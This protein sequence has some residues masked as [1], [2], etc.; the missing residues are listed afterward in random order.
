MAKALFLQ[1]LFFEYPGTMILSAC[2]KRAG[3][4]TDVLIE[5]RRE[6]ILRYIREYSPDLIAFSVMTGPHKWA[7]EIAGEIKE[8]FPKLLIILGGVHA[9]YFPETIESSSIDIICR[10][11]GE[12]ALIELCDR[13]DKGEDFS[14]IRNLW[15]KKNGTVIK[16]ELRNL[17]DLTTLPPDDREIYYLKYPRLAKKTVKNLLTSR[18]CPYECSFCFN[19]QLKGMYKGKGN[20]LR[21]KAVD[22]VLREIKLLI[23]KYPTEKILFS[24]DTFNINKE[25]V[26]EFFPRLH[27]ELHIPYSCHVR[28]NLVDEALAKLFSETGCFTVRMAVESGNEGLRMEVLKKRLTNKQLMDAANLLHKYKIKFFTYNMICLPGETVENAFETIYLNIKMRTDFPWCSILMP[29]S[30]TEI[31]SYSIN[32]GY[33]D[34]NYDINEVFS[35]YYVG[36]VLKSA[37]NKEL[38][39]LHRFFNTAILM[40]WT[41]PIIKWLIKLPNNPFFKLWWG[42]IYTYVYIRSEGHRLTEVMGTILDNV[43]HDLFKKNTTP[44]QVFQNHT[45]QQVSEL[46]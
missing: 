40:P 43:P 9:T 39:N 44:K 35:S 23:D 15:V 13:L 42:M 4:I 20:Y 8:T 27:R 29:Y 34:P 7:V 16:N 11:E 21:F 3:H 6:P 28:A 31:V 14:E 26:R 18:G 17:L 37:N 24:D 41:I 2:L 1:D 10:G 46:K 22:Q 45:E 33:L 32:H 38:L 30:R 5:K 19:H 36:T 25:W 12:E